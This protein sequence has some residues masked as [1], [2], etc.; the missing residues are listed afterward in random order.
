MF[1]IF[2][3]EYEHENSE[4]E[5]VEHTSKRFK[6]V[7]VQTDNEKQLIQVDGLSLSKSIGIIK[8]H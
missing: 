1:K 5:I 2:T 7:G 4:D 3:V 8:K 6:T